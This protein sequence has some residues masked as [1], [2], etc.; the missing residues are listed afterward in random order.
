MH[1]FNWAWNDYDQL[2]QAALAGHIIECGAQ[3]TGGNFTD[4]RVPDYEHIGFPGRGSGSRR[5][6]VVTKPGGFRRFG[7][8]FTVGEQMLYEIGDPRAYYLP[9][10]CSAASPR[11]NSARSAK[12]ALNCKGARGLP[13]TDSYK[14]SATHP[15]GFRCTASCLMAG[16]DAVNKSPARQPGHHQQNRGA[17]RRTR[18]GDPTRGQHRTAGLRG[19]LRPAQRADT[20]EIVI[21]IAVRTPRKKADPVLP[22]D[23]SKPPPAWRRA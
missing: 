19:D 12:I 2:A 15:D 20:R 4:W 9:L 23:R 13:P 3:C 21:K 11:C 16:I 5:Q 17:V 10:M 7:H 6:F 18:L 14:V 22:R 8:A 1:E